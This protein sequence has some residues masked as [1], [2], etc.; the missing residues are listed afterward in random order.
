MLINIL[1]LEF[2]GLL[3]MNRI[4]L[5]LTLIVLELNTFQKKSKNLLEIKT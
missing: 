1:I 5:L 2:I 4:V 3:C